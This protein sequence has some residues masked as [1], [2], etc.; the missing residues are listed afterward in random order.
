MPSY[1]DSVRLRTRCIAARPSSTLQARSTIASSLA[2]SRRCK[3]RAGMANHC[4]FSGMLEQD[5]KKCA[6]LRHGSAAVTW[7]P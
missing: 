7:A 2:R 5:E 3:S 6:S 1:E 4:M